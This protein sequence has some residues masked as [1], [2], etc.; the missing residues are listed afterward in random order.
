MLTTAPRVLAATAAALVLLAGCSED[1]SDE[2]VSEG[3]TDFLGQTVAP[4]GE[5]GLPADYPR[6]VAPLLLG[7]A[8][9]SEGDAAEG[10]S[11]TTTFTSAGTVDILDRAV[12]LLSDAGWELT[13]P[14][15]GGDEADRLAATLAME[16]G[17]VIIQSV[18]SD[19]DVNLTYLVR[20][21]AA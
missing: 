4:D 17:V 8:S 11:I 1:T 14:A 5:D 3:P 10:Y 20:P 2:P 21:P 18:R 9:S 15:T 19:D 16:D 7:S 6:D 12:A 13:S